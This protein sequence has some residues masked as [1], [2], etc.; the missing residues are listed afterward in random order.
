MAS[1]FDF[2]NAFAHSFATALATYEQIATGGAKAFADKLE[3][4]AAPALA[5]VEAVASAETPPPAPKA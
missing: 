4:E 1:F 3:A 5:V 2:A